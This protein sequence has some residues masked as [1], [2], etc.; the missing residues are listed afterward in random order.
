MKKNTFIFS[1]L[2][3]IVT[4]NLLGQKM[5]LDYFEE[6]ENA[7][8]AKN[9]KEALASFQF[10]VNNHPKNEL[11]PRA[12]YNLGYIY[13]LDKQYDNSINIFKKILASNFNEKENLGGDIMADPYT[14]YKHR[15]SEILSD[16]YE[17]RNKADT[18]LYYFALSDTCY[19]YLHFCG[20]EYAEYDV[21]KALRYTALYKQLRDNDKAIESLL[22]AVFITLSD[23]SEVLNELKSLLKNKK[24]I[25]K[26]LDRALANI[27]L[28][29]IKEKD[30]THQ[31]H[32]FKFLNIEMAVPNNFDSDDDKFDKDKA[33]EGIYKTKFYK[34]IETL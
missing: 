8:E 6:G 24:N 14:N 2:V 15:A 10:I 16:I 27:Y 33:K 19:P 13:Y 11:F 5:P 28:I 26:D 34:L 18:A 20:N 30:E 31:K 29:T 21:H 9:Y 1:I 23:N 25:K 3:L 32:C 17:I 7:C 12:V 22:P 4:H